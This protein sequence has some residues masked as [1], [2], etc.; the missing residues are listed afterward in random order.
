MVCKLVLLGA[1]K[2]LV[3]AKPEINNANHSRV[4]LFP[5]KRK[6]FCL[7]FNGW[8]NRNTII[9]GQKKSTETNRKGVRES[10]LCSMLML[11][12][13]VCKTF[14]QIGVTITKVVLRNDLSVC[15][16]AITSFFSR[17][18]FLESIAVFYVSAM[19]EHKTKLI[20]VLCFRLLFG[21]AP[22]VLIY[23]L[24]ISSKKKHWGWKKQIPHFK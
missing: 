7:L 14:S 12:Q 11:I 4:L 22:R 6:T 2:R 17:H 5:F 24:F 15:M 20:N 10:I 23:V 1:S 3:L 18:S 21:D 16:C 19:K 9:P 8:Q 13:N